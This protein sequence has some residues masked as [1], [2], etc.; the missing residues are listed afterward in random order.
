M[1]PFPST[2]FYASPITSPPRGGAWARP[3]VPRNRS[4]ARSRHAVLPSL[5]CN[6]QTMR[7][8]RL[9]KT[10]SVGA[11]DVSLI[12]EGQIKGPAARSDATP[13]GERFSRIPVVSFLRRFVSAVQARA[14]AGEARTPGGSGAEYFPPGA[15]NSG[16]VGCK[17][18]FWALFKTSALRKGPGK[19]IAR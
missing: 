16:A 18:R 10:Y 2:P 11:S 8:R 9:N 19:G 12:R 4:E 1:R 3:D 15:Q 7:D 5:R 6:C 13:R 14:G 17:S